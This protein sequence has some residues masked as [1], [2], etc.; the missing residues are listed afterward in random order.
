MSE[1]HDGRACVMA[2]LTRNAGATGRADG[3][4]RP[5]MREWGEV[6]LRDMLYSSSTQVAS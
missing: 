5:A 2:T 3:Y 4:A 6:R 1:D